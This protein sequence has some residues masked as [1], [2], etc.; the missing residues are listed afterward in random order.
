MTLVYVPAGSFPMGCDDCQ[1]QEERPVHMV[2][3]DAFWMDQTEVTNVM[4]AKFLTENGNQ[5]EEGELWLDE[6][7]NHRHL[8][9]DRGVWQAVENYADHPVI[10]VTWYGA[11]DYC[12]WADRQLPSEA[13]WEYA[14]RGTEG[15]TYPMGEVI[16]CDVANY[17]NCE[18]KTTPVGSYPDGT[19]PF[20]VLDMAGNVFEW[21]ADWYSWN[22]YQMSY[23][24]DNP[25][26][27]DTGNYRVVRGGSWHTDVGDLRSSFRFI[28]TMGEAWSSLGFRCVD[29]P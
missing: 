23:E 1:K 6:E 8:I 2:T 13:Q 14:A 5:S 7:I 11:R 15:R 4:Y 19:S 12:K 24:Y 22:Y 20:G 18:G 17:L 27:P 28:A 21:V 26:G 9:I 25:T 29:T 16:N 3:L 10:G